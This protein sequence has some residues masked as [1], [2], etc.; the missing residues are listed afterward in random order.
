MCPSVFDIGIF[1]SAWAQKEDP[2]LRR[3]IESLLSDF[4][5]DAGVYVHHVKSGLTVAINA[6]TLFPT[7]SMIKYGTAGGRPLPGKW[8]DYC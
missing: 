5:G 6:D 8:R 7:A 1:F 4:A 2:V 3:K